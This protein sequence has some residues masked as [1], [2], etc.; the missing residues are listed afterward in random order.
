MYT[1]QIDVEGMS[2]D[3]IRSLSLAA[4]KYGVGDLQK[5][6]LSVNISQSQN[7]GS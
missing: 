3:G 1:D 4:A 5:R 2:T 6:L 7:R